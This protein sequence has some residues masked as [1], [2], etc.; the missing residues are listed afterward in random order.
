MSRARRRPAWLFWLSG[1]LALGGLAGL[2]VSL[3]QLNQAHQEIARLQALGE[4]QEKVYEHLDLD[5]AGRRLSKD[6]LASL[7]EALEEQELPAEVQAERLQQFEAAW[8][9]IR[10]AA[11]ARHLIESLLFKPT[12]QVIDE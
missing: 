8:R 9:Q 5:V 10:P 3:W 1:L 11:R 2:G 7:Q 6:V 4:F 12:I